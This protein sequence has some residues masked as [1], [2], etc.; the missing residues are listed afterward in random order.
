[1]NSFVDKLK[2]KLEEVK[3]VLVNEEEHQAR[4]A[5]CYS[6]EHFFKF[7]KQCKKCGCFVFGKTKIANEKCPES[8]WL[9]ILPKKLDNE[10]K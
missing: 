10:V 9:P 7:T 8:K 4:L 2:N 6:C 3:E 1:M 5:L